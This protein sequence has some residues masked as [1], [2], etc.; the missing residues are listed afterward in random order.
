MKKETPIMREIQIRMSQLGH[1]VFRNNV[2]LFTTNS[3]MKI[4]TGL[5]NGSSDLIGWTSRG[6]FLSIEVKTEGEKATPEQQEFLDIVNRHGGIGFIAR[7][8]D[9]AEKNLKDRNQ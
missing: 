1:R 6:F 7:S 4:K 8:A 5:C 3:G 2:G 9:E